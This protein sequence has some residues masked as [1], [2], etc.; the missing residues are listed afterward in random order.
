MSP[1]KKYSAKEAKRQRTRTMRRKADPDYGKTKKN[2]ST[3]VAAS[4]APSAT[5]QMPKAG[6][7]FQQQID[8]NGHQKWWAEASDDAKIW[9]RITI[10][11]LSFCAQEL[12]RQ[13]SILNDQLAAEKEFYKKQSRRLGKTNVVLLAMLSVVVVALTWT[14][15]YYG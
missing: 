3:I 2:R 4:A 10:S 13:R 9:T 1:R 11:R 12:L 14:M 8:K 15:A 7:R 5:E 6:I